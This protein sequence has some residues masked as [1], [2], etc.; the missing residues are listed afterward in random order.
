MKQIFI[1]MALVALSS[2]SSPRSLKVRSI[3]EGASVSIIEN[4]GSARPL[5]VTPLESSESM[6]ALAIEKDGFEKAHLFIGRFENQ[7]YDYVIRLQKKA[8]DPK[9]NDSRTKQ[10][11]VALIIAR[12]NNLISTRRFG[13]AE[14][15]LTNLTPDFPF[16]SVI[17]DLLGNVNYLQKDFRAALGYY[18]KSLEL[19]PDNEDTKQVIQRLRAMSN[20]EKI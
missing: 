13:E 1:V 2:C 5:G 8:D 4:D 6:Q 16:V 11:R 9:A 14:S 19:N 7:N 10:E 18:E 12:A 3:P 20:Q 15:I 17:Y